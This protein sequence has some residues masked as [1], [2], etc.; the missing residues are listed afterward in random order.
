MDTLFE[1]IS[2]A[3]VNGELP[4]DFSL[5]DVPG[6][7]GG[8][9]WA[10]GA[11]DGV[12]LY[13]M[14]IPE[15]SEE[16]HMLM[17]DAI[18]AAAG[19]DRDLADDLFRMLGKH[20]RAIAA[21][22]DLQDYIAENHSKLDPDNLFDHGMHLLF[23]SE[24]RECVKY[25]LALLELFKTDKMKK[26]KTAVKTIGLCNEFTL[27]AIIVMHHWTDGNDA[28]WE[29]AKKTHGWGRIHAIEHLDADTE[30][31]RR[32]LLMDGVHNDVMPAYSALTCWEGSGAEDVLRNG[33]SP[34]EFRAI[35]DII[36]GLL[37]EGPVTGISELEDP[38]EILSLYLDTANTME[39]T[40]DD[41][42]VIYAIL[43]YYREQM[44]DRCPMA[45]RCRT[46]LHKYRSWCLILDAAK[47][48]E[49]VE[50]AAD[51]G[52]DVSKYVTD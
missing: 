39:L 18:R 27:F 44:S 30:E 8:I 6:E 16:D 49:C 46:L 32:W 43:L 12:T 47:Q 38:D 37:D 42:K 7:E 24:D 45:V 19:G 36:E 31:I 14:A 34:E 26:L 4:R 52:A 41:C 29:L 33:P 17:S 5:P 1:I 11:M 25:G 48:G 35:G 51:L 23:G 50:M 3:V 40:L 9:R 28:I 22:E 13:H 2:S 10:D 21:L 15:V 20:I